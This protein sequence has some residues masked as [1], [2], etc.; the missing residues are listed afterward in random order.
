MVFK[1]HLLKVIIDTQLST[2]V[3]A[4]I[5][6]VNSKVCIATLPVE[7]GQETENR[8]ALGRK[9]LILEVKERA[10]QVSL[11]DLM[12]K[13]AQMEITSILVEGGGTLIGSLFDEGLVDKMMFFISPK[14]IGG[15]EATSSVMGKGVARVDKAAKLKAVKIRRIGED[16]LVE[17]H[18][19]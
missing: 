6:S 1:K 18:L 5:F 8:Q 14:I 2:P 3:D 4:N 16:F 7:K 15:K 19:H 10:G 17:G 9:A 11:R 13:L 12:R